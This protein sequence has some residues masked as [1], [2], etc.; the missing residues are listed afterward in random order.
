MP[1]DSDSPES[2]SSDSDEITV[3]AAQ[4]RAEINR[5]NRL[6]YVENAP[7]LDD[8]EW[9]GRMQELLKLEEAH[10]ALRTPDSPTQRVGAPPTDGFDEV[11][12]PVPMLSLGNVFDEDGLRVW[13]QRA[14]DYLELESAPMVCELKD[15]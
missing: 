14:L 9:D 4:L 5:S 2:G 10:P 1:F 3:R 11:I 12:H 6:Y 7:E 15:R 13:Y 8:A